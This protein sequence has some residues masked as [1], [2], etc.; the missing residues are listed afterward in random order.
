M[1]VDPALVKDNLHRAD[2]FSL[3]RNPDMTP[4]RAM[5]WRTGLKFAIVIDPRDA[6]HYG[7]QMC[8]LTATNLAWRVSGNFGS[9]SVHGVSDQACHQMVAPDKSLSRYIADIG[10]RCVTDIPDDDQLIILIGS[11]SLKGGCFQ[12]R[13]VFSDWVGG[14]MRQDHTPVRSDKGILPL[15]PTLAASMAVWECFCFYDGHG[16]AVGRTNI[17]VDLWTMRPDN[18]SNLGKDCAENIHLPD[19]LWCLGLG[20]LGQAYLWL[21]GHLP[22]NDNERKSMLLKIQDY[23]TI[24]SSTTS[25]SVLSFAN[26]IGEKKT[27]VCA[28]WLGKRGFNPHLVPGTFN[29]DTKFD[30]GTDVVLG[31]LDNLPSRRAVMV[32]QPVLYI[33][34]GLGNRIDTFQSM[35]ILAPSYDKQ[36]T[37]VWPDQTSSTHEKIPEAIKR[38]QDEGRLDQ[39][40][41]VTLGNTAVGFPFVGMCAA[42]MVL[43]QAINQRN[44]RQVF[45]KINF[46]LRSPTEMTAR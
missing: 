17:G 3:K 30:F 1:T 16:T 37:D 41:A 9:V 46:D 8:L 40:G 29:S 5:A 26:D 19:K 32:R 11:A 10:G 25:T 43:A 38:L 15:G 13:A 33:D 34:A 39:C 24:G 28:A 31:G 4:E 35:R 42:T 23:D 7:S 2:L 21:I 12:I 6:E 20:H 14:I 18:L 22:Y 36:P 27:D 44:N 45:E